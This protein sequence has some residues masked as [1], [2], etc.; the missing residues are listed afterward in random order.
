M[1]RQKHVF[2]G[3]RHG[4]I[5]GCHHQDR[6]IHLR[7]A[8]D[9]VLDV[10]GV[11]RAIHMRVVPVRRLILHVRRRDG[12]AARFFFRSVINAVER[13]EDNLRIMLLQHLGNRR[14]QRGLAMVD[15]TNRPHIAVRLVPIKFLFR[16]NSA[17][18]S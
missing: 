18:S 1:P 14:R 11:A 4:T 7:R 5:G 15:V 2:A 12:D 17:L 13:P 8:R 3:L 9:H 16:H 10:V 6:A